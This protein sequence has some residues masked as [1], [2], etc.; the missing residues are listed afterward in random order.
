MSSA[1]SDII[2]RANSGRTGKFLA[3]EFK[4]VTTGAAGW[5]SIFAVALF[6]VSP[7]YYYKKSTSF[8]IA[9]Q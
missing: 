7:I 6:W 5:A 4:R 3:S 8:G 9:H 2:N 1:S